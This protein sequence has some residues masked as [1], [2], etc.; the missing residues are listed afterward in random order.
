MTIRNF[1]LPL[2]AAL[3]VG[4]TFSAPA[5]AWHRHHGY[6]PPSRVYIYDDDDWPV[7]IHEYSSPVIIREYRRPIII[8]E[9]ERPAYYPAPPRYYNPPQQAY[10]PRRGP[11]N[12]TNQVL[13]ALVG[14]GTGGLIGNQFGHGR[15]NIF[16]TAGGAIAGLLLGSQIGRDIDQSG[17]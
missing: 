5:A 13:G 17:C 9:Y 7:V 12:S 1:I 8:H 10:V 15:G 3:A 11:C 16:A 6:G 14:G 2:A 4:V